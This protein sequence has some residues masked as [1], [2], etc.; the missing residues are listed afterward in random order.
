MGQ[1]V[2]RTYGNWRRPRS[3]GIGDLD[4]LGS[5]VLVAGIVVVIITAVAVGVIAGDRGDACGRWVLGVD[6]DEGSSWAE[7]AAARV[8]AGGVV[9]DAVRRFARVPLRPARAGEVGQLSAAW[10]AREDQVGASSRTRGGSRS[11]CWRCRT[12]ATYSVVF[13]VEPDGDSLVDQEQQ[14]VWVARFGQYLNHLS[15]E[16]GVIAAAVTVETAPDTGR[17]LRDQVQTLDRPERAP[18]RPAGSAAR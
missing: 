13:S 18:G 10:G 12:A 1:P 8:P 11:G 5:G 15:D 6:V 3:P 14:D 7:R 4:L 2:E 17:R 9:V 16:P